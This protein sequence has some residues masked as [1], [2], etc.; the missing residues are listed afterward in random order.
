MIPKL[1]LQQ[2]PSSPFPSETMNE[3]I[4]V[5]CHEDLKRAYQDLAEKYN[6]KYPELIRIALT[7]FL[8]AVAV[9]GKYDID[10][11]PPGYLDLIKQEL[12]PK[13]TA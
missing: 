8:V 7:N 9:D 2:L 5:K 12:K 13:K 10:Q 6:K 3:K 4:D 11:I 1:F